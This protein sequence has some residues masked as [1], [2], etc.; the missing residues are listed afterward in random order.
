M[1]YRKP[2][3]NSSEWPI[4]R[5][6]STKEVTPHKPIPSDNSQGS[7]FSSGCTALLKPISIAYLVAELNP[8]H[9]RLT[10]Q[11]FHEPISS[12]NRLSMALKRKS[13]AEGTATRDLQDLA[14]NGVFEPTGSGRS[15]H[16]KVNL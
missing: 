6:T 4:R 10:F 16:Y 9:I 1:S 8:R 15:T 2:F 12:I 5:H 7:I 11:S 13:R 14:E 3:Y